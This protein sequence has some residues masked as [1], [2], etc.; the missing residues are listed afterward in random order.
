MAW[1]IAPICQII[2][3]YLMVYSVVQMWFMN[4]YIGFG[5]FFTSDVSRNIFYLLNLENWDFNKKKNFAWFKENGSFQ[6]P[7][8]WTIETNGNCNNHHWKIMIW[9]FKY[10]K[11]NENCNT[12]CAWS[13]IW[14]FRLVQGNPSPYIEN[15]CSKKNNVS[16][17]INLHCLTE[18][19]QH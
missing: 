17:K 12:K 6:D 18:H 16:K 5:K 9:S 7:R 13:N 19:C 2:S 8:T 4:M 1:M 11:F 3:R 15:N 14:K 10:G